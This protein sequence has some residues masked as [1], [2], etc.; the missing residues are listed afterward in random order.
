MERRRQQEEA[1]KAAEEEERRREAE[2]Q[3]AAAERKRIEEE[4]R[5]RKRLEAKEKR[6]Q[7]KR[8]GKLLTGAAKAKA[9]RMAAMREQLFAGKAGPADG[10]PAPKAAPKVET[11][12]QKKKRLAAEA[13]ARKAERAADGG[14]EEKSEEPEP[15]PEPAP[16][17]EIRAP[18]P[19]E[20]K[21]EQEDSSDDDDWEA[22]AS[23]DGKGKEGGESGTGSDEESGSDSDSSDYSDSDSSDWS[24]GYDSDY[25]SSDDED[26]RRMDEAKARRE[27]RRAAAMASRNAEDLR[28][29]ICCILGHVDTGKTKILDNVRRTNVQEGEA[30]GITQ[31]IGAT[32][33]PADA[34]QARTE[35]L[36]AGRPFKMKVPGL[37]IIDT[38]GHESF[39]N[40]RSRG[41]GL[42]DIAI[43]VVDLMHGLEQQT[44]ESIR[45]LKSRKTPFI[46]AMNKIDRLYD[47][48]TVKDSPVRTAFDRQ[49]GYVIEE[50][51]NR[52]NEVALQLN[53]EGLNVAL[54]WENKDPRRYAN[55][56]PTSAITGEGLPDLMQLLVKLTQDFMSERLMFCAE[57]QATVLEVKKME[58]LGSTVDVVLVNGV[59]REGDRIIC[60]GLHG[61]I[62]TNIRACLTPHP[63]KEIRVKAQYIHHK[64]IKAAMGVKIV[65]PG[66][67]GA[68]AGTELYVVREGDDE[69]E[70]MRQVESERDTILTRVDRT[71]EGVCV[72][73][74]TLGSMEALL[75]FLAS[76]NVKIPVSGI[77]LGPIHKKDV[78]R[79]A[80]MK[81]K[82]P[83]YGVILAFDVP[84]T[85]EAQEY[86]DNVEVQ[87]FTADIIYH[88]F[89]QFSRYMERVKE[90]KQAAAA[91]TAVFPCRL[92]ILDQYIFNQRDPIVV[93]VEVIDGILRKS[94]PICVPGQGFIGLGK[95]MSIEKE[96]RECFQAK[97]GDQVAIKIVP[98]NQSEQQK[99]YGRHF[100][101]ADELVSKISRKSIDL[102]KENFKDQLEQDDWK[103]VVKLKKVFGIE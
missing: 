42:C 72:Q 19:V 35:E 3:A 14:A 51:R 37:L 24:S 74:S 52:F 10:P 17:E 89:D 98:G 86:A 92:K 64:E 41:S 68:I 94:T 4:E 83:E 66:L 8:E 80:I 48:N 56:V 97:R 5:E 45:L 88:L 95:V 21:E 54:Y 15:E 13:E 60:C 39:S 70:I 34:I 7:L 12:A 87:I 47:W 1:K 65:A 103:L 67:E 99:A 55:V 49:K 46:I 44:R 69:E 16:T 57:T 96:K 53:E 28:S 75:D 32:Y 27:A 76:D 93:G 38:P 30:G 77:A 25:T 59:L 90:E 58:G 71:G 85:K 31:Q 33:V 73:S 100:T 22:H 26:A 84:V 6:E 2:E 82:R 79:A 63:L 43:L 91:D 20:E 40:L 78:M 29:P 18:E 81:E 9:D 23:D 61:A 11:L 50:F 36:R 62:A 101:A 102:L